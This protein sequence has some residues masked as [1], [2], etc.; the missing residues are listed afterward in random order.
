MPKSDLEILDFIESQPDRSAPTADLRSFIGDN[1]DRRLYDLRSTHQIR[2][3]GGWEYET[4]ERYMLDIEG[5][6]R[7]SARQQQIDEAR[8]READRKADADRREAAQRAQAIIDRKQKFRHDF[9]VAAF[10]VALTLLI[11][12]LA[13]ILDLVKQA[14]KVIGLP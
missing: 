11:E 1:A 14:L 5:E 7:L 8:Q 2:R 13:D 12:H 6:K 3:C 9:H 4:P 10:S